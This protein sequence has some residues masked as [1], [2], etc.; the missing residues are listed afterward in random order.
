MIATLSDHWCSRGLNVRILMIGGE[1]IAYELDDRIDIKAISKATGGDMI[2]RINR[3]S[4]LRNEIKKDPSAVVIAM[5]T[6]AA[7]FTCL[8]M[9]GLKNRL[10]V[11]E[12][13][14]PNR[15]NHRPIKSHEKVLRDVL[16]STADKIVFQTKMAK[17]CF[18]GYIRKK[19]TIVMNPLRDDIPE[20]TDYLQKKK[21]IMTAGRL[22]EQKNHKLLIDA[23]LKIANDYPEYKLEIYGE[24]EYFEELSSYIKNKN[25]GE[26]VELKGFNS[27]LLQT[28]CG[29]R[30]YVSSSDWEGISNSLAEAMACGMTVIATDCPMGGSAML[31]KNKDNGI[32]TKVGDVDGLSYALKEILTDDRLAQTISENAVRIRNAL[33]VENI[34]GQWE[35]L[36]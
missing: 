35:E 1:D 34:A 8:S 11:S 14:D 6:V 7:M 33:S 24:G 28:M 22:T 31:I 10:I 36:F 25:A 32:L 19:G 20:V 23:F 27:K 13:N 17:Q 21:V 4:S 15:L 9:F 29:S 5:G 16:Y 30:I 2:G 12:R 26:L 3:L 18:P